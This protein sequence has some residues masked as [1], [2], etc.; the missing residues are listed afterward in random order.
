MILIAHSFRWLHG[1]Q[2]RIFEQTKG[3]LR[4]LKRTVGKE[5]SGSPLKGHHAATYVNLSSLFVPKPPKVTVTVT[6]TITEETT[7]V[8]TAPAAGKERET[9]G[10]YHVL[11]FTQFSGGK[12]LIPTQAAQQGRRKN[13]EDEMVVKMDL[14]AELGLDETAVGKLSLFAVFDGHAGRECAE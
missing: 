14:N 8:V 11:V 9:E 6:A 5:K 7:T 4:K 13:M 3:I 2:R 10:N 12:W 1:F